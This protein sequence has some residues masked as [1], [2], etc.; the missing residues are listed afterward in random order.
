MIVTGR[1][2]RSR[3]FLGLSWWQGIGAIA[4]I[5]SVAATILVACA[6]QNPTAA[7]S[8]KIENGICNVQGDGGTVSCNV[9]LPPT[10]TA[11]KAGG[12]PFLAD[13]YHETHDD[14]LSIGSVAF[15]DPMNLTAADLQTINDNGLTPWLKN[16]PGAWD[17]GGTSLKVTI[18]G[19]RNMRIL[20][21][22]AHVLRQGPP[23]EGTLL[24]PAS[25]GDSEST[26]FHFDLD[27]SSPVAM[28]ENTEGQ[29]E[30]F[31]EHTYTLTPGESQTFQIGAY[32]M[33]K[34]IEWEINMTVLESGSRQVY[35]IRDDKDEPFRTT[36]MG[37]PAAFYGQ[38][39]WAV[40]GNQMLPPCAGKSANFW[41]RL[42]PRVAMGEL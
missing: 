40:R 2:A 1:R 31:R 23:V 33:D 34:S 14:S 35:S 4:G 20:G 7:P 24:R 28:G 19:R 9:Q 36:S 21:M 25:G 17:V 12:D 6:G 8:Q 29:Y 13:I 22:R 16:R 39:Y 5:L 26:V 11:E 32:T 27:S 38:C 10:P 37:K 41:M 30:Y 42:D 15:S 3:P 18:T